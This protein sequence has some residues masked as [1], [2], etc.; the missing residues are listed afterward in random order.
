MKNKWT[1]DQNLLE[2]IVHQIVCHK[3]RKYG[4]H[5]IID[6]YGYGYAAAYDSMEP[7]DHFLEHFIDLF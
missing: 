2:Y 3:K 4:K 6:W 7:P 5:Y 1:I